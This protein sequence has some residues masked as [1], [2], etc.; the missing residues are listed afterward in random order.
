MGAGEKRPEFPLGG[1]PRLKSLVCPPRFSMYAHP[2]AN[3]T[4]SP[5]RGRHWPPGGRGFDSPLLHPA[6]LASPLDPP[7]Y[8]PSGPQDPG[9][10]RP[11]A[12]SLSSRVH[13]PSSASSTCPFR[14]LH[15]GDSGA[16]TVYAAGNGPPRRT[17]AGGHLTRALRHHPRPP[18]YSESAKPGN[19]HLPNKWRFQTFLKIAL[20]SGPRDHGFRRPKPSHQVVWILVFALSRT[21]LREITVYGRRTPLSFLRAS[22]APPPRPNK[23]NQA[24]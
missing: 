14:V 23:A 22:R 12:Q 13:R 17:A 9:G 21:P 10:Y 6:T 3:L 11:P 16:I 1:P 15:G 2:Y 24:K 18:G 19:E 7:G 20:P 5:V 8:P 4:H